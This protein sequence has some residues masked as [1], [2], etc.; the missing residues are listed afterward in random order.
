VKKSQPLVIVEWEDSAQPV[1]QWQFADDISVSA[2]RIASVGW[3]VKD[4]KKV[5]ALA[6]NIGGLDGKTSPQVS[7]VIAIPTR[8]VIQIRKLEETDAFQP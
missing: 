8:C 3:L 1:S 2:V 4:G 6:P 7:G 5:K